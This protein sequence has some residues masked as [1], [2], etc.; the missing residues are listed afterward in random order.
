MRAINDV[1]YDYIHENI[2]GTINTTSAHS[3]ITEIL[4]SINDILSNNAEDGSERIEG[5]TINFANDEQ[6]I[7]GYNLFLEISCPFESAMIVTPFYSNLLEKGSSNILIHTLVNMMKGIEYV[8]FNENFG[9]GTRQSFIDVAVAWYEILT[10]KFE[11]NLGKIETALSTHKLLQ[12]YIKQPQ[13]SAIEKQLGNCLN[14]G[15]CDD[16]ERDLSLIHI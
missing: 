4:E 11:L 5:E 2:M 12:D 16:I 10:I 9:Y 8:N 6:W 14:L 1:K 7:L 15:H 13:F 3:Q